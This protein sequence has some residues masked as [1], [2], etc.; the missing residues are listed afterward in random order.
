MPTKIYTI[1]EVTKVNL[2]GPLIPLMFLFIFIE[3]I[4][5]HLTG[6]TKYRFNDSFNR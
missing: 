2:L 4:V 1:E 6:K 5:G 3:A